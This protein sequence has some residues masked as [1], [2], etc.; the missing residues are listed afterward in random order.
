MPG[1]FHHALNPNLIVDVNH[2]P[3]NAMWKNTEER[4]K[5]IMKSSSHELDR[6]QRMIELSEG[7]SFTQYPARI[8]AARRSARTC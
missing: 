3:G 7:S 4:N 6:I 1:Y 2:L 8:S 5:I